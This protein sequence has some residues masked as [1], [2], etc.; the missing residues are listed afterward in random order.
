MTHYS[1]SVTALVLYVCRNIDLINY[2]LTNL[3]YIKRSSNEAAALVATTDNIP[4]FRTYLQSSTYIVSTNIVHQVDF[5]V[6]LMR[7]EE[8][9]WRLFEA[10]L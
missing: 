9:K 4:H 10:V 6:L 5:L 3:N 1:A 7:R 2:C 8:H